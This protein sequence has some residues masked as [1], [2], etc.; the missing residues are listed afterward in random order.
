M[1][2]ERYVEHLQHKKLSKTDSRLLEVLEFKDILSILNEEEIKKNNQND[3]IS[4]TAGFNGPLLLGKNNQY[5]KQDSIMGIGL[6]G[7]VS[8]TQT[9]RDP[10][11]TEHQFNW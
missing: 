6:G 4:A 7:K 9:Q 11:A 5:S 10:K 3:A 2:L 1:L 8:A